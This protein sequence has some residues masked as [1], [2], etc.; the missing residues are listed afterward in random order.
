MDKSS[1]YSG[2][3]DILIGKEPWPS[4]RLLM[5]SRQKIGLDTDNC[6]ELDGFLA[7]KAQHSAT[8]HYLLSKKKRG[9]CLVGEQV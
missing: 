2:T 3:Q 9:G 4:Q 5:A 8:F 7:L 6:P 1:S